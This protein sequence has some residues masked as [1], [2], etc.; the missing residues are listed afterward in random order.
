MVLSKLKTQLIKI[1]KYPNIS[2]Q[3][4]QQFWDKLH[5]NKPFTKKQRNP[6]H[7]CSF[8]LPVHQKSQSIYLVDHIKANDWMPPG[9]HLEPEECPL[10]TVK[11][12]YEEELGQPLLKE[13]IELIGLT[14]KPIT[15]HPLG[16]CTKHY[17]FWYVVWVEEQHQYSWDRGEFHNANWY[18]INLGIK[19]IQKN[20]DYAAVIKNLQQQA[21]FTRC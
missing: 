3:V 10:E 18:E 9:G 15:N 2:K 12:E 17:D 1:Q 14:I 21:F 7:F 5:S 4:W 6:E 19:K 8:F 13:K 11:R 20:P 16:Y